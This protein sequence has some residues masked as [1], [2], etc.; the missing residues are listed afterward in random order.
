[1]SIDKKK[2]K[3]TKTNG[4]DNNSN[5][6]KN[7]KTM[8]LIKSNGTNY[9]YEWVH[10]MIFAIAIVVVLLTFFVRLV[11]V[12]GPSML[13]TLQNGDKVIITNF[14]YTPKDGDIVVIS[15]GAQ[16]A[17]PIIKR[18]IATEGQTLD[19]DFEKQ[20]V[21]VDGK[22]FP[23]SE[24]QPGVNLPPMHPFCRS[25]TLPV[26]PSE[27]ELDREIAELGDEIG[28]DVNFDEW[29]KGLQETEDGKLVYRAESVDKSAGRRMR[30]MA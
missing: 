3:D 21:T 20:T 5:S 25:T 11:D 19:I 12:K 2:S 27:E 7:G 26:L 15:H 28:A 18:V 29:V 14:M 13:Q 6:A 10:S 17:E 4:F 8:H 24:A 30:R 23:V 16:Y 1:M 22:V 9:V